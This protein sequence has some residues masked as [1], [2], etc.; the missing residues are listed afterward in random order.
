MHASSCAAGCGCQPSPSP[1]SHCTAAI[2]TA[3]HPS[4]TTSTTFMQ[5]VS[6]RKQAGPP[7]PPSLHPQ[8]P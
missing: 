4:C 3:P 8:A 1:P 2:H 5:P 7:P 6:K